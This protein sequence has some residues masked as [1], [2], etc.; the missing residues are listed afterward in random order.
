MTHPI[1][2]DQP[3]FVRLRDPLSD[4]TR[5]ERTA[6]LGASLLSLALVKAGLLP[7]EISA[8]GLK[9][10][11]SN[12]RALLL[13]LAAVVLYY[14][15]AFLT[16]AAS[17]YVAWHVAQREAARE[18]IRNVYFPEESDKGTKFE[19]ER[20]VYTHHSWTQAVSQLA[21]PVS[22]L[23]ALFDFCLPVLF[24]AYAVYILLSG[25]T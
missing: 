9:L 14:L 1:H 8:L 4:V 17:D 20:L 11:S 3:A 22:W 12:H 19:V 21:G 10:A 16:Y 25:T 24:S 7:T 13:L 5:R 18:A 23:R 2:P 15:V 6:L